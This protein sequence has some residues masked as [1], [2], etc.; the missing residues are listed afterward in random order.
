MILVVR[1]PISNKRLLQTWVTWWV[2]QV[3]LV[4]RHEVGHAVGSR[5][6]RKHYKGTCR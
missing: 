6:V 3:S 1:P 4:P 2:G 5:D